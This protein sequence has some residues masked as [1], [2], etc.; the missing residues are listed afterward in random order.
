M[1]KTTNSSRIYLDCPFEDKDECKSLGGRWDKELRRWYV[2]EHLS[3]LPFVDWM[4]DLQRLLIEREYEGSD[5]DSAEME[6]QEDYTSEDVIE[7]V[8]DAM[9]LTNSVTEFLERLDPDEWG[10]LPLFKPKLT[11]Q[12]QFQLDKDEYQQAYDQD[13]EGWRAVF[14]PELGPEELAYLCLDDDTQK[15][16]TH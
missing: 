13:P 12:E 1:P 10:E 2:P 15:A 9:K 6:N 7:L 4:D 8:R 11:P 5:E 3:P 16:L 14:Q